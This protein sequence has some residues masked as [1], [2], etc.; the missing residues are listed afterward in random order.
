MISKKLKD[1][2]LENEDENIENEDGHSMKI[3]EKSKYRNSEED[4]EDITLD[5]GDSNTKIFL[6]E[7]RIW[8]KGD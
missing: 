1:S 2:S 6:R 8:S 3:F 5:S 7:N 4:I